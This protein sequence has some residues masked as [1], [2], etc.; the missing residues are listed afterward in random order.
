[1]YELLEAF[2]Q[3]NDDCEKQATPDK[4]IYVDILT[5]ASA[6][7]MTAALLG[8]RLLFDGA[9]L[10][11]ALT[12]PLYRTWVERIDIRQLVHLSHH[13]HGLE[14][15]SLL[16]SDLIEK[17]GCESLIDSVAPGAP[18]SPPHNTLQ[19]DNAGVPLPLDIG[20]A[21]TN[22]N[23]ID[24]R[25]PIAGNPDGGFNYTRSDDQ[26]L[27]HLHA[28]DR[29]N[30]ALWQKL[31][32]AAV[33]CGAFPVA[34]RPR[35][36]KR[37]PGDYGIPPVPPPP[38]LGETE[39]MWPRPG[40]PC[41]FAYTDGGVLQN[42]PLGMAKNF[43]DDRVKSARTA[44]RQDATLIA[45][46]RLYVLVSPHAVMSTARNGLNANKI[47]IDGILVELFHTYIRQATFHDWIVAEGMNT[48][49]HLL[50]KRAA[51]LAR[52]L[53]DRSISAA[54]LVPA[55]SFNDMLLPEAGQRAATLSR[56]QN[57][58]Q[59]EYRQVATATDTAT[60][61]AFLE[62]V[63]TLESAAGLQ[64]RDLMKI[65]AVIAD[66]RTELAGSGISSF[67]GFFSREFRDHDYWMGRV[68]ARV[69]LQRSDVKEIL[70]VAAWP[71]EANWGGATEDCVKAV[72]PNPTGI[73]TLPMPLSQQLRPGLASL[74]Y[75]VWIRPALGAILILLAVAIVTAI[76]VIIWLLICAISHLFHALS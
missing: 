43:V 75:A 2:R 23:G 56:L 53:E 67:V 47:A 74:L 24:Y 65:V 64:K 31:R 72:L 16:S 9:S 62:A 26:M 42:Q 38:Q 29:G 13:E 59:T 32:A 55:A 44:G 71:A 69:Y 39:V 50:D 40:H 15:N 36:L 19:C 25:L 3:H 30:K 45:D 57:Q 35:G 68:K 11:G 66:G 21:I 58:Y 33:A 22:L 7:G 46:D 18:S 10:Q 6:G 41:T 5:G 34:F 70:Q 51:Q 54:L 60:A 61:G 4:K 37:V 52:G 49:L 48:E 73:N 20:V 14:W 8:Q 63:A 76:V 17:I 28:G 12:N 1:M 27:F